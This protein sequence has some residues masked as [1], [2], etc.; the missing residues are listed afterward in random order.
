MWAMKTL[1]EAIMG[2]GENGLLIGSSPVVGTISILK[3]DFFKNLPPGNRDFEISGREPW[4]R[5]VLENVMN[6]EI[7]RRRFLGTV[8]LAG[9]A[10]PGTLNCALA[11]D[12]AEPAV[13][14][15]DFIPVIDT[16]IHLYDPFR[17]QGVPW[18][19]KDNKVLYQTS[20]PARYRPIAE[21]LGI[22]GAI[23]VE[24]SSWLE[25]N[26][27][28]LDVAAKEDIIVGTVGHLT[29]GTADFR[30]NLDRFRKNPRFR[31]I[32]Y[33]LGNQGGKE[34]DRPEFVADLKALADADLVLDTANPSVS[35]LADVVRVS[36]CVPGLRVVIDHLPQMA[37]PAEPA[38]RAS[39][40][41]SMKAFRDRPQIYAK[42]SEVLRRL[43]D[44]SVPTE[45]DFYR[46][47]MEAILDVFGMDRVLYGS[48][49]P[50]SD[51]WLPVPEGFKIVRDFFMAKGREAAEK[52]FWR[53]SIKCYKWIKRTASQPQTA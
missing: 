6:H 26:Q 50:N 52:Y 43:P 31:G 41:A 4:R 5:P 10:L 13:T 29:P 2:S 22:V 25:D 17:P 42:V 30:A 45:L 49:W 20:L 47:R 34:F 46:P 16:H 18:P 15:P 40:D 44:G 53:N 11:A 7:S 23:E 1:N 24:C 33:W 27:W 38:A 36:D 8:A 32:R 48:D 39:Y 37:L 35:L 51:Q 14:L 12:V 3:N 21:P 9:A 19:G 28:V